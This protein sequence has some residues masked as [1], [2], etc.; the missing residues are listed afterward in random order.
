MNPFRTTISEA[1][2][3]VIPVSVM[4]LILGLMLNMAWITESNRSSRLAGLNPAQRDRI[5]TGTIDQI[6][7][8]RTLSEE[9]TRLREDKTRLE[10]AMGSRNEEADALNKSLQDTKIYAGLVPVE[11]PGIKI[12]LSDAKNPGGI[13]TPDNTI[14]DADVL[15]VVNELWAAG[16]EAVAVNNHRVV[17]KS[18]FRCVGPVIHVDNVP[19]ASPV[20][21]LAIGDADALY[22]GLNLPGGV[23]D[24][25]R[26]TDP[27]MVRIEK[28]NSIMVPAFSGTTGIKFAK[29]VEDA[30]SKPKSD[31][32]GT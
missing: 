6:D 13:V 23:L 29:P 24:E 17:I 20:T 32:E 9:V 30:K 18:S 25:I 4:A 2:A 11:G 19:I 14:H 31:G 5:E 10:K 8:F 16:A 21:I 12:V 7:Q 15:K 26:Q 28:M 3:W 1:N 22:G 27:S